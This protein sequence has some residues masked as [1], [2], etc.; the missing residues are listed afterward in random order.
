MSLGNWTS[1]KLKDLCYKI[2][3]GSHNP[4]KGVPSSPYL[5]LSSKNV[6][7]DLLT[8]D[9]PRYL[10]E[11]NYIAEN[12]RTQVQEGD[13][14]LTIVGTI[15]RAAV[16]SKGVENLTFQRSVAVLKPR[17]QLVSSRFLMYLLQ[18]NFE[19]L[20][21][22]ARG[23]AQK[24]IYLRQLNDLSVY[25]PDIPTQDHIVSVLDDAF[26]DLEKV[27]FKLVENSK[28]AEELFFS[29]LNQA[30]TAPLDDNWV[31]T[32]LS[33]HVRFID[34]R[35]RTP[36]KTESGLKLITAKNVKMGYLQNAPEEFVD[37]NIYSSW[38]VRGI[39]LMGDILFSTEAPMGNVATLHTNEKVVFAQRIIILQ[40]DRSI[41]NPEFLK[42]MLMSSYF[43]NL[44]SANGTGATVKG[45]KSSILKRLPIVFPKSLGE[46]K[47][48][49]EKF[50]RL[51]SQC[52]VLKDS[53]NHKKTIVEELKKS[54]LNKAFSGEL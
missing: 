4:P 1:H 14:L 53:Y 41:I 47:N 16:I 48:L 21:K 52:D 39:P 6:N 7:N 15:G 12:K 13:V 30:F 35:G 11:K 45:I 43:Q 51:S 19:L 23:V 28:N 8:F 10:D 46:Q 36:K 24:G 33:A 5:M 9:K 40:P 20:N 27:S 22:N 18:F 50:T 25:I 3:D 44:L 31:R 26:V 2:T 42:F 32:P 17:K 37:E 49:A 34:Y 29:H 54:I 38:M